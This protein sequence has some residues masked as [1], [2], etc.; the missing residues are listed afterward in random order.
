MT[1]LHANVIYTVSEITEGT[2]LGFTGSAF[3]GHI[4]VQ[5]L[6]LED[7]TSPSGSSEDPLGSCSAGNSSPDH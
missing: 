2:E 6:A 4:N 7:I 1:G 3:K 5:H